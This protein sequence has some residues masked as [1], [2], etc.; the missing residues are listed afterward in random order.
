VTQMLTTVY[1]IP[2]LLVLVIALNLIARNV[3]K[4]G[5][6]SKNILFIFIAVVMVGLAIRYYQNGSIVS[7]IAC[8][9]Y[10]AFSAQTLLIN[11][12]QN[13]PYCKLSWI[14]V[15]VLFLNI[16][17]VGPYSLYTME[18]LILGSGINNKINRQ[19]YGNIVSALAVGFLY[20]SANERFLSINLLQ[21]SQN[22]P[23]SLS[24]I[25][26]KFLQFSFLFFVFIKNVEIMSI[27]KRES[28]SSLPV[29][30]SVNML[31]FFI[32]LAFLIKN[33]VFVLAMEYYEFSLPIM[34]I[35]ILIYKRA[36]FIREMLFCLLIT[37]IYIYAV[38]LPYSK[39]ATVS[40]EVVLASF[41]LIALFGHFYDNKNPICMKS[42]LLLL[43]QCFVVYDLLRIFW[44]NS[45]GS[46]MFFVTGA[47]AILII[48]YFFDTLYAPKAS[49]I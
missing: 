42:F 15:L 6:F 9:L 37:T 35:L 10:A 36:R 38:S 24:L 23:W 43:T 13:V 49:I 26:Q 12:E 27:Y 20:L 30:P 48:Y 40:L 11:E 8:L 29:F 17:N 46:I 2:L 5:Y 34:F 3:S 21:V 1:L 28:S 14:A 4:K 44:V 32:E 45:P 22:L 31:V 19:K 7:T 18:L 41:A 47:W 33:G 25:M 16:G 39:A